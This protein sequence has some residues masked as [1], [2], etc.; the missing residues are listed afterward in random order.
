MTK[1]ISN[2]SLTSHIS[3]N[4][5]KCDEEILQ[6][7]DLGYFIGCIYFDDNHV[8]PDVTLFLWSNY[9]TIGIHSYRIL[10]TKVSSHNFFNDSNCSHLYYYNK[11]LDSICN[12]DEKL[13]DLG[14][15]KHYLNKN[16]WII[17]WYPE[18][19][20]MY[21]PIF[22]N[23]I[24]NFLCCLKRTRDLTKNIKIYRVPKY[25]LFEIIKMSTYVIL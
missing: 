24:L 22:K 10:N 16:N 19:H 21:H 13:M 2:Q 23:K 1:N 25:I 12:I 15:N 6:K 9:M 7:D 18:D 4:I 17:N 8:F 20:Y 3:K 11:T 5:F 14:G